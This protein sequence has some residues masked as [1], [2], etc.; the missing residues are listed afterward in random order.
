[1][2]GIIGKEDGVWMVRRGKYAG[3]ALRE[4]AQDD[5]DYFKWLYSGVDD[6]SKEQAQAVEDIAEEEGVDL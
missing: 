5:S 6:L 4:V 2:S 1:M 3:K